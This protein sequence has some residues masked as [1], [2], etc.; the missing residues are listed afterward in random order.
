MIRKLL[1]LLLSLAM[2]CA[3]CG[4]T[5]APSPSPAGTK[6]PQATTAAPAPTATTQA[7]LPAW[8]D[9]LKAGDNGGYTLNVYI[10]QDKEVRTLDLDEYLCG[11][12]AGEMRSDWPAEALKAQAILARTFLFDFLTHNESSAYSTQADISTDVKE[13]QA[14]DAAGVDENIKKAVADTQGIVI[15]Y[16][17]EYIKAWFHSCAGGQTALANEGLNYADGNPPYI[18]SVP[19]DESMASEEFRSWAATFSR[20]DLVSALSGA[21]YQIERIDS[22]SITATGTS[23]RA[24][25]I[26]VNDLDIHAADFRI[27]LNPLVFRSTLLDSFTYE[28]GRLTAGGKGFGHGVGMSQWGAYTMATN[29]VSAEEIVQHYFHEV[30]IVQLSAP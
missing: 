30:E 23:G 20:D 26:R 18:Q 3:G 29:G 27:A 16:E 24:L 21:G 25:T 2:V 7:K 8:P 14:Y 17:G 12:L 6:A 15:A 19:S 5:P 28:N 22:M 10:A 1:P 9:K 13:S 11:V 4:K